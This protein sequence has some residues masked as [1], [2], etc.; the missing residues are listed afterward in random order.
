MSESEG[1]SEKGLSEEVGVGE[2]ELLLEV[3]E[4][5]PSSELYVRW[6]LE[7]LGIAFE[8]ISNERSEA[9][10]EEGAEGPPV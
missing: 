9:R 3:E 10:F 1:G 8:T 4:S 2:R 7:C 6:E 5:D